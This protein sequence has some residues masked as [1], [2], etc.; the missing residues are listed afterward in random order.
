MLTAS[1]STVEV[2]ADFHPRPVPV[3]RDG[4][5]YDS[6]VPIVYRR[7][8]DSFLGRIPGFRIKF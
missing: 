5:R 1:K 2:A 6:L 7:I 8:L 4:V 3:P